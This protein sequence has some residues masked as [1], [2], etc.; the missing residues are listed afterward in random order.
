MNRDW[1]KYSYNA[2]KSGNFI[3]GDDT[4]G[5][6]LGQMD[7]ARWSILYSQLLDL[8]VLHHPIDPS[9]AYTTQFLK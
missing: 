5:S 6:Q 1:M 4:S 3:T 2:L 9:S 7:P 8:G